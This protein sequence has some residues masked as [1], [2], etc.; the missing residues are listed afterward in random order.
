[1]DLSGALLANADL[2]EANLAGAKLEG[3]DLASAD[4]T[5]ANLDRINLSDAVMT[6]ASLGGTTLVASTVRRSDLTRAR[7]HGADLSKSILQQAKIVDA[8]LTS[9]KLIEADLSGADLTNSDMSSSNLLHARFSNAVITGLILTD[10]NVAHS[11]DLDTPALPPSASGNI[12][13]STPVP[14]ELREGNFIRFNGESPILANGWGDVGFRKQ[15]KQLLLQY[16]AKLHIHPR[17]SYDDCA[18]ADVEP[19][20]TTLDSTAIGG[21][22]CR[23]ETARTVSFLEITDIS[24]LASAEPKVTLTVSFA[25]RAQGGLFRR[26][27]W[28]E[29]SSSELHRCSPAQL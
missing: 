8:D 13:T 22:F 7:L 21:V 9:V 6:G 24:A 25:T 5:S 19:G 26:S 3:A 14:F 4:L 23:R 17:P 1:V 18:K 10:A 27:T 2:T 12:E 16:F 20:V 15:G 29:R 28:P 11:V